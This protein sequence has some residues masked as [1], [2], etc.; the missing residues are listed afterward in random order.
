MLGL[1]PLG[2]GNDFARAMD[3][4][5]DT[6]EAARLLVEGEVRPVDLI[7]DELGEVVVNHVHVGAGAQASRRGARW[8]ERLGK[9][10]YRQAQPRQA[11]L[12]DRRR[13]VR[14]SSRRTSGCG[15][16]WTAR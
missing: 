7:V 13:A 14:R 4:P 16:R 3:I 9:V 8:K 5:L 15:S 10:G 2:T 11:R 1:I 12:P 6:E